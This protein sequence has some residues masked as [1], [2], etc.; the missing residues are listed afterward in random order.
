M[1][2]TIDTTFGAVVL[3]MF[4]QNVITGQSAE[5]MQINGIDCVAYIRLTRESAH[6][7]FVMQEVGFFKTYEDDSFSVDHNPLCWPIKADKVHHISRIPLPSFFTPHNKLMELWSL[8]Q[9]WQPPLPDTKVFYEDGVR[10]G[11]H[12]CNTRAEQKVINAAQALFVEKYGPKS[13]MMIVM[14]KLTYEASTRTWCVMMDLW[15]RGTSGRE[16]ESGMYTYKA[17]TFAKFVPQ[18]IK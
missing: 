4:S 10:I 6:G 3:T 5:V 17:G 13:A 8:A 1:Q 18:A 11:E 14:H 12:R 2:F 16:K 15:V 7:P 9:T